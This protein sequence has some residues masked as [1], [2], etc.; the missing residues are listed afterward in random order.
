M[1]GKSAC[2]AM[3]RGSAEWGH[4]PAKSF[5]IS[6]NGLI[7]SESRWGRGDPS[8]AVTPMIATH[9]TQGTFPEALTRQVSHGSNGR[10]AKTTGGIVR[11]FPV[12]STFQHA[13][14]ARRGDRDRD[15]SLYGGRRGVLRLAY[16]HH[17]ANRIH[18]RHQ[19]AYGRYYRRH[20]CVYR[21]R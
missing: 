13:Y 17:H 9:H 20:H 6:T 3:C 4:F 7:C 16:H 21:P 1:L 5:A 18:C 19:C 11:A 8:C 15:R 12:H 2:F 10:R 14:A